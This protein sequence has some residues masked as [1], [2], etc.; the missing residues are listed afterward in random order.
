[1]VVEGEEV[2]AEVEA[3]KVA[4]G[5]EEKEVHMVEA[6]LNRWRSGQRYTWLKIHLPR[7]KEVSIK[8]AYSCLGT[9]PKLNEK[10]QVRNT[11]QPVDCNH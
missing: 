2:A 9:R 11:R 10:S 7:I 3:A 1:M 4:K 8:M 5:W 6:T